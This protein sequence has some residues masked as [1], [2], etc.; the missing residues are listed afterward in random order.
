[1]TINCEETDA[2]PL[3]AK[4]LSEEKVKVIGIQATEPTLEEAFIKLVKST[5]NR[6]NDREEKNS[7]RQ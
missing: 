5:V 1:V 3:I 2:I 6:H 4:L 7:G